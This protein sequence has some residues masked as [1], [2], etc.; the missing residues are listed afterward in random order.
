VEIRD[1]CADGL[2][3]PLRESGTTREAMLCRWAIGGDGR[4]RLLDVTVGT[5]AS[6]D[7]WLE[8][9]RRL[10]ERGLGAPS[11]M[12]SAGAPGLTAALEEV[13]PEALRQR[14]LAH[15][16]R[17][18]TAKGS[19]TDLGQ[20]TADVQSASYASS[21]EVARLLSEA[22]VTT[23]PPIYPSAHHKYIRTTTLAE[24]SMEEE[25]RR[26]KVIPHFFDE[27]GGLKRCY[28]ALLRA[29]RRWQRVTIDE[30][31]RTRLAALRAQLHQEFLARRGQ[32]VPHTEPGPDA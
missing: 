9:L 2:D 8:C 13:C 24:R 19:A 27:N 14:C 5:R 4:Q 31:D 1:L 25:R 22:V 7:A 23:W 20:V 29:S 12:T 3:D 6:R 28:A 17:N 11:V 26:P 16:G 32:R 10:R 30:F 18:V 15:Q 21:P